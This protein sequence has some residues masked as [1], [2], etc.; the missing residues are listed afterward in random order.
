[1]AIIHF[2]HASGA[3]YFVTVYFVVTI[4]PEM[5]F[6][7]TIATAAAMYFVR[8]Y[9]AVTMVHELDSKKLDANYLSGATP[10]E[11]SIRYLQIGSK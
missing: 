5:Y 1:M 8:V 6:V 7:V 4:V 3:A 10:E 2:L 9:F 11:L